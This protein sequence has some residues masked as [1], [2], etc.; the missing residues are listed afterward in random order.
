L[1]VCNTSNSYKR[2]GAVYYLNSSQRLPGY[3]FP[4]GSGFYSMEQIVDSVIAH[5]STKRTS[6]AELSA[7]KQLISHP[8][9]N[10]AYHTYSPWQGTLDRSAFLLHHVTTSNVLAASSGQQQGSSTDG[11]AESH[12]TTE[13]QRPMTTMVY[14]FMP[15]GGPGDVQDYSV[16]I[17]A[18]FYTRWP[19]HT[20]PGQ[21]MKNTPTAPP[22]VI[23]N[24]VDHAERTA[25]DEKP[26]DG[27]KPDYPHS[28]NGGYM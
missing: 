17:R 1:S 22:H 10:T 21:A 25:N 11:N 27:P 4:A 12:T 6:G 28:G 16:T 18:S 20:A 19:L 14:V 13:M 23:N 26:V 5:P 3:E 9:D 7:P 24:H 15:T 2:G 8:V